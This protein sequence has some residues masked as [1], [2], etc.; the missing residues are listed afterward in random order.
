M[1]TSKEQVFVERLIAGMRAVI[2]ELS[3]EDRQ[4][5]IDAIRAVDRDIARRLETPPNK[6]H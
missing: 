2:D 6:T 3:P 5:A 1:A 4:R